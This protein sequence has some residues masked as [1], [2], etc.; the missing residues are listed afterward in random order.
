MEKKILSSNKKAYYNYD[1]FE[2]LETGVIL[3]GY[4]VKSLKQSKV[5]LVDSI[6]KFSNGEAFIEN[7]S[8][9]PYEH[10]STH[11]IDYDSKKKRK[12]LMHKSEITKIHAKVREKGFTIIPLEIYIGLRCKIKIL[13]GLAK[14]KKVYDK[15]EAIKK[16]DITREIAR[17]Y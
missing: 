2:K 10:I 15:R 3:S 1:I 17:G 5:S 4:E 8:I 13:V 7:M 14:G 11:I 16:R 9:A 12:L 6:V